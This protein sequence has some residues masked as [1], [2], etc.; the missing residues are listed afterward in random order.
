VENYEKR[1]EKDREP[2]TLK[3]LK[4]SLNHVVR[5][6]KEKYRMTDIAFA[7]YWTYLFKS[8]KNIRV[9]LRLHSMYACLIG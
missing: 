6:L 8:L 1:I 2:S 3:V 9:L 7:S 5:F 4:N